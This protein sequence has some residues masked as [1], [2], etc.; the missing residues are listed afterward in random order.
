MRKSW[1]M[2]T[3]PLIPRTRHQIGPAIAV[4]HEVEYLDL[5][6]FRGPHGR[7]H[8]GVTLIAAGCGGFLVGRCQQPS[9]VVLVAEKGSEHR[10]GIVAWQA[11]PVDAAVPTYKG[12]RMAI[13]DERVVLDIECHQAI[14]SATG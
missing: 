1:V 10:S 7:Q 9:A 4:R 2:C 12:R 8:E 5:A 13:A 11:E 3:V 6:C 14:L